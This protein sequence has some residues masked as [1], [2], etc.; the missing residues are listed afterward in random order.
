[1]TSTPNNDR[2]DALA[3]RHGWRVERGEE[4]WQGGTL[5]SLVIWKRTRRLTGGTL[6]VWGRPADDADREK[7]AAALLP[8]REPSGA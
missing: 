3:D 5:L 7:L 6:G 8:L 1:M 4:Q 2:L